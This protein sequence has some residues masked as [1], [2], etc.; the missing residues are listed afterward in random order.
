[1]LSE[2]QK[3]K[4]DIISH[5]FLSSNSKIEFAKNYKDDVW[6]LI[7]IINDLSREND[8][9]REKLDIKMVDKYNKAVDSLH[10]VYNDILESG[11]IITG[12]HAL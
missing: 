10:K 7:N 4:F 11:L 2:E 8:N 9:L 3:N 6:G 12:P 5:R 1:M